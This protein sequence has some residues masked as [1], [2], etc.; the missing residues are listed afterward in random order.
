MYNIIVRFIRARSQAFA[1][2]FFF[3]KLFCVEVYI[4]PRMRFKQY[5]IKSDHISRSSTILFYFLLR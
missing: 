3:F 4:L 5:K 2:T 1:R